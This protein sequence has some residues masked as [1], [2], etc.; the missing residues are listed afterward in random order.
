MSLAV[1]DPPLVLGTGH[2]G[3]A[4]RRA[5]IRWAWRLFRREWRQQSLVLVLLLVAVAAITVGLGAATNSASSQASSFGTADHLVTL[6][7]TDESQLS[8]DIDA[9]RAAF[10]T[11]EV[12]Q[13]QKVPIPGSANTIDLRAQDP[14]GPYGRSMLRLDSGRYP[15]GPDEVAVTERVAQIFGLHVGGTWDLGGRQRPVVGLVENPLNLLDRFVLAAPGQA[16]PVDHVT[17]LIRATAAEFAAK[18]LPSGS[19]IELRSPEEDNSSAAVLVL[20]TIGLLFVGLLAVA[21]FTVMAQRRLRAL[22][23][24]GAIGASHR[25]IR[26]V[27][28]A[29]GAVIGT[30]G[31]LAGAVLGLATWFALSTQLESSFGHRIDRFNLPWTTLLF[32]VLLAIL[33]SIGA[34]WW[35]AR[36]AARVPIVSALSARPATPRPAHRFALIGAALLAVGIGCL[37]AAQQTKQL[38]IVGGVVTTAL[39]LLLLAPVGIAVLGRLARVAPLA[40]RLAL[41]DLSRYRARS[42][43][44]LAAIALAVGIA[45]AIALTGATAVAKAAQPT[46]GNLPPDQLIV[47]LFP[48]AVDGAVQSL[49]PEQTASARLRVDAITGDLHATSVL[50]LQAPVG[51]DTPQDGGGLS[52]VQLGKP[53]ITSS[54]GERPGVEY[55]SKLSVRLFVATPEM[56][57]HYG[58]NQASIGADT[59]VITSKTGIDGYDLYPFGGTP[60]RPHLQQVSL[61]TYSS[62]PTALMTTHGMETLHLSA[63]PVG[64]LV[65]TPRPLTQAQ[66]DRAQ[67]TALA[68]GLVVETRPTGADLERLADNA[69]GSG[70]AVALGVLVMTVGLI[71]SETAG[72]LRTLTAAGA[73]RSTRRTLTAATAGALALLGA[74]IGTIGAYLALG[75]WYHRELHWLAHVPWVNLGAIL[76]GLPLIAYIGGWLLAGKEAPGLARQP[77]D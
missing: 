46:G 1:E 68:A 37:V 33:T 3:M 77:L 50:A 43:A 25:H 49:T 44:A 20:A 14:N 15:Q 62:Q 9:L 76:L 4:A 75:A 21:G 18:T 6:G 17:V 71:R 57:S 60:P 22:G 63:I 67:Q 39:G 45:A 53:T 40:P 74:L 35:P 41:R 51:K 13:Y 7:S 34:S 58:I 69:T 70:I 31:A 64:W 61:P 11:A 47:W 2:G 5:V 66:I 30:V 38:F 24:L 56:L 12:I 32:A 54:G 59:D 23:M 19:S 16:T 42:G 65:Q 10:G 48:H 29:N 8:A 55:S 73:R 27:M 52:V 28:V 26:L 72:D 36:S